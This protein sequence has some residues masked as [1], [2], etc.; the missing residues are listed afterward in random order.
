MSM[1][2]MTGQ[3]F[4]DKNR[5]PGCSLLFLGPLGCSTFPGMSSRPWVAVLRA[6]CQGS[7]RSLCTLGASSF[8]LESLTWP[9]T[10]NPVPFLT[11]L[12]TKKERLGRQ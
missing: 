4:P 9:R 8:F 2:S 6:E 10:H 3:S 5:S 7:Y 1:P 12:E 11:Q